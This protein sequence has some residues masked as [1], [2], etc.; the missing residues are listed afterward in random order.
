MTNNLSDFITRNFPFN[1][2]GVEDFLNS[3]SEE[4]FS[5]GSIILKPNTVD[6]KL[7]YIQSGYIRE[8][9]ATDSKDININ[10]FNE[11]QFATDFNSFISNTPTLKWQQC[12]T[13]VTMLTI[14]KNKF[15]QLL[16]KYECVHSAVQL[17]FQRILNHKESEE[18]NKATK[19]T[20]ERY[21]EIQKEKPEWLK[22]IAQYH[23]ASY[24]SITPESLSRIRNNIS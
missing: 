7:K 14:E 19:S 13:D 9:Y 11:A 23:I 6:H 24:L 8:F 15:E 2:E 3:F 5:K 20:Q 21:K 10:F 12:L 22:N 16:N 1:K 4:V 18:H 17:S